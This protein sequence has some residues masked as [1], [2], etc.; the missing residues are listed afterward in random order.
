[1][2]IAQ[3]LASLPSLLSYETGE[4]RERSLDFSYTFSD[5]VCYILSQSYNE[6]LCDVPVVVEH[7]LGKLKESARSPKQADLTRFLIYL[8]AVL[9]SNNR[10]VV[11]VLNEASAFRGACDH[12]SL[13]TLFDNIIIILHRPGIDCDGAQETRINGHCL[14]NAAVLVGLGC[15]PTEI[16]ALFE[17][18]IFPPRGVAVFC[19]DVPSAPLLQ[20]APGSVSIID[21]KVDFG[22]GPTLG[23]YWGIVD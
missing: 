6:G 4:A 1:M 15:A 12:L 5:G 7:I 9:C 8:L 18:G 23:A 13:S 3:A 20:A 11:L 14:D 16:V 17:G 2:D 21:L 19:E 22:D 10:G